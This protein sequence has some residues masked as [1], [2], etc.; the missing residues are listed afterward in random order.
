MGTG[1]YIDKN[2]LKC[3]LRYYIRTMDWGDEW[4][5]CLEA[6]IAVIDEQESFALTAIPKEE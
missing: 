1:M 5:N 6:V 4:N 3:Q 2:K